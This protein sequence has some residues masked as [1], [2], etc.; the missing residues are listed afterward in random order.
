MLDK[1]KQLFRIISKLSPSEKSYFKKYCH[2]NVST[3]S[4]FIFLFDQIDKLLKKN[5]EIEE[6]KL[7]DQFNKKYSTKNYTKSK[8]NLL[9]LLLETIRA[10]DKKNN[11]FEK[12][13]EY[14]S[15]ANLLTERELFFDAKNMLRKA[16][17]ISEELE[18]V[19]FIIFIKSK[20]NK[21]NYYTEKYSLTK[22]N[23]ETQEIFED[24]T[25]LKQKLEDD[26][27][28]YKV[29]QF[30]KTIGVP[31]SEK[32]I[33]LFKE[34]IGLPSFAKGYQAKFLSTRLYLATAKSGFML[35]VGDVKTVIETS[36]HLID[37]F[38]VSLKQQKVINSSYLSLYDSFLQA[39]LLTLDVA[40]FE[41]YYT[42]FLAIKTFDIK[43]ENTK[44]SIDLYAKSIY[45]I[46]ADKLEKYQNLSIEFNQ[47][48]DKAFIH[49][50]RKIS[51]G[52]YMVIG[53]FLAENYDLA[54]ENIQW[55]KNHKNLGI[56]F[57]IEVAILTMESIIL[58]EKKEYSLLEYQARSFYEFLKNRERK[59]QMETALLHFVKNGIRSKTN[60]ERQAV[61][62]K[63][64][65]EMIEI[66]EKNPQEKAFLNSFDVISW[67]E[68]KLKNKNFKKVY[69]KN[70][71]L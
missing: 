49:N 30:Q 32:D 44:T 18:F 37:N 48:K 11:E 42:K 62:E 5:K 2:K 10:Y 20:I 50:F 52:Y 19:E 46:V 68:S 6:S 12:I 23:K 40:T 8:S 64:Y 53:S 60:K 3:E 36:T 56:R 16:L 65:T 22:I 7:V 13:F 59:F 51:L 66:V 28:T 63:S 67:L 17:K 27:A 55:L 61:F 1:Q 15:F 71:G 29:V 26:I 14:I 4:E 45:F 58:L 38:K 69:Y 9:Q 25:N 33:E 41:K 31:R 39:C 47:I 70:N 34:I 57:D 54:Y 35:G 24:I 21:Y 43:D